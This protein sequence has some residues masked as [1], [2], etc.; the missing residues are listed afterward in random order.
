MSMQL[1]PTCMALPPPPKLYLVDAQ[2]MVGWI[3]GH[4]LGFIGFSDAREAANAAWVA[5]R[6]VSHRVARS[7]GTRPVPIDVEPLALAQ[8]GDRE[9]ILASGRPVA[10]LL[11]PGVDSPMCSDSFGFEI[12]VSPG[13]SESI[14]RDLTRLAYRALRKSGIRWGLWR[15][16]CAGRTPLR[17]STNALHPDHRVEE[18][19]KEIRRFTKVRPGLAH[20]SRVVG[21]ALGKIALLALALL[22]VWLLVVAYWAPAHFVTTLGALFFTALLALRVMV[23]MGWLLPAR[24]QSRHGPSP[25]QRRTKHLHR[26][27]L[28]YEPRHRSQ[29]H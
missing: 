21:A 5:H 27:R 20:G 18:T 3:A 13:A 12:A 22:A 4:T 24:P 7:W 17:P 28:R 2:Q 10:R 11:P 29:S 14:M 8:E 9:I 6:T 26:D 1:A 25:S 23:L 15:P 16:R 19:P